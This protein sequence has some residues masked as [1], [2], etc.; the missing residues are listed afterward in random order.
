MQKTPQPVKPNIQTLFARI[1]EGIRAQMDEAETLYLRLCQTAIN[2]MVQ[3]PETDS[4][5]SCRKIDLLSAQYEERLQSII[6]DAMTVYR[7]PI[8]V[9]PVADTASMIETMETYNAQFEELERV[10]DQLC[11]ENSIPKNNSATKIQ[12]QNRSIWKSIV[13]SIDLKKE[14]RN[15]VDE[16]ASSIKRPVPPASGCT[17]CK[18]HYNTRKVQTMNLKP[19]ILICGPDQFTNTDLLHEATHADTIP[20]DD[21][22]DMFFPD[23]DTAKSG[24]AD[25]P[26]GKRK[27]LIRRFV[28]TPVANFFEANELTDLGE[29]GEFPDLSMA[30]YVKEIEAELHA[31]GHLSE[32]DAKIDMIWFCVGSELS[33][34]EESEKDFIRSAAGI[35]N[36]LII[37]SPTIISNRAEFKKEIDALTALAGSKRV[38]LAPSVSTGLN[39]TTGSSGMQYLIAKTKLMYWDSVNAPDEERK[40]YEAAWTEFYHDKRSEWQEALNDSLSDCMEQAAGRANFILNKPDNVSLTDLVGEGIDLLGELIEILRGNTEDEDKPGKTAIAHTVELKENI[41]LMI[42]EIA[43]C[44]GHAATAHDVELV[45]RHSKASMLPKDAAAITYAVAQ[46]AKAV[47]EPGTE[48]SSKEILTIYR[49][50]KEEAMQMEFKPFDDDNPLAG[51]DDDFELDEEDLEDADELEDSDMDDTDEPDDDVHE[52]ADELPDDCRVDTDLKPSDD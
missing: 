25:K 47:Y 16:T 15:Q 32:N 1:L 11:K 30:D 31:G 6:Q 36:A 35:S 18:K 23:V 12:A 7:R 21:S 27:P 46:V 17:G 29:E 20:E 33:L 3:M 22:E 14:F 10:L 40:A 48:Y 37:A 39:F 43:A 50:A 5:S 34:T 26:N 4:A 9:F 24:E 13:N 42:Y 51:L 41:E 28:E 45:L 19:N 8:Q 52:P 2:G 49:E 38:V 44:Y